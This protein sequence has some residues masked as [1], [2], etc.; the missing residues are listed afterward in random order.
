[1]EGVG[2]VRGGVQRKESKINRNRKTERERNQFILVRIQNGWSRSAEGQEA[3]E[4]G[5]KR[6]KY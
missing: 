3:V 4:G 2:Q 5:V 6:M 1:M